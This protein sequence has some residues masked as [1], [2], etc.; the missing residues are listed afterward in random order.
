MF[1]LG[2]IPLRRSQGG[3][4]INCHRFSSSMLYPLA[5]DSYSQNQT[6]ERCSI[7]KGFQEFEQASP[8][9]RS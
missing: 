6:A 8:L 1:H 9:S 2:K 5:S 7:L 4:F 3:M